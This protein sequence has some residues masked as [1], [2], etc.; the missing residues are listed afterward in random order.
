M[1]A[2]QLAQRLPDLL[3][4]H[5]DFGNPGGIGGALLVNAAKLD[6][7]R[8]LHHI[9]RGHRDRRC[10]QAAEGQRPFVDEMGGTHHRTDT[11]EL[12]TDNR[13]EQ[14]RSPHTAGRRFSVQALP[15]RD[16]EPP[17]QVPIS[18]HSGPDF[19]VLFA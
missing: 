2:R 15:R 5:D 7:H 11:G 18:G 9:F 3:R 1:N 4:R 17:H 14:P 10:D 19:K 16:F 6:R 12:V 8:A 13:S